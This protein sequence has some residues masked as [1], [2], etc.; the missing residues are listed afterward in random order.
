LPSEEQLRGGGSIHI[1]LP[2]RALIRVERGADP[3]MVR[4]IVQ[5]VGQ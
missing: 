5:S 1:E 2:G 4:C 3:E